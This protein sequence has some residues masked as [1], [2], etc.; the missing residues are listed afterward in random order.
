[1]TIINGIATEAT[2]FNGCRNI[3]VSEAMQGVSKYQDMYVPVPNIDEAVK[4]GREQEGKKYDFAG[5]LGLPFLASEDWSDWDKW[6]CSE[7]V[8]MQ[9][10]LGGTW[11]LDQ[12]VTHRVTP[13]HLLMCNFKKTGIIN[14]K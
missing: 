2:M 5:A 4:F 7:I 8:F 12:D 3:P 11:L 1:M 9:L 13:A 6:W 10:G 14:L